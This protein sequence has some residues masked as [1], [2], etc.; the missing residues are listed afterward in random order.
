MGQDASNAK[1]HSDTSADSNDINGQGRCQL[2][3][4]ANFS[5]LLGQVPL[6]HHD[7]GFR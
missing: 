7:P 2:E 3:G 5:V 6:R 1:E 4:W